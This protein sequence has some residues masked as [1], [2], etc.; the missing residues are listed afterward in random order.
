MVL[1]HITSEFIHG[2]INFSIIRLFIYS[3]ILFV[4]LLARLSWHLKKEVNSTFGWAFWTADLVVLAPTWV[5]LLRWTRVC[6]CSSMFK[7]VQTVRLNN[8]YL[9]NLSSGQTFGPIYSGEKIS[10]LLRQGHCKKKKCGYAQVTLIKEKHHFSSIVVMVLVVPFFMELKT[11]SVIAYTN[12][13]NETEIYS[14]YR[15]VPSLTWE[16]NI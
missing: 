12:F 3:F 11:R 14:F 2:D 6:F 5:F 8:F 16:Q 1:D 9:A 4:T 15:C 10:F 7:L 13:Q